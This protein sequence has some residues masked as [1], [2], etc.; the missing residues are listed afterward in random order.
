MAVF[1]GN[2]LA[3]RRHELVKVDKV[4]LATAS[5]QLPGIKAKLDK[6]LD[7]TRNLRLA[8]SLIAAMVG[9][10]AAITIIV[11]VVY[12]GEMG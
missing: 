4:A 8:L 11:V 12:R 6:G 3:S 7:I 10:D 5:I 2:L 1:H 9:A